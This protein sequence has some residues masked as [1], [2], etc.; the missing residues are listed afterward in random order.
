MTS[1]QKLDVL[2]M[3]LLHA[4]LHAQLANYGLNPLEWVLHRRAGKSAGNAFEMR[5]R[6]DGNFRFQAQLERTA[7]GRSYLKNLILTSI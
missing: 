4:Q 1:I 5:H 6:E 2:T 7:S 3:Q